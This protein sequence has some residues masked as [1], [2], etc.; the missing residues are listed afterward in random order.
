MI[1]KNIIALCKKKLY[2]TIYNTPE[3]QFI[4]DGSG[5]YPITNLPVFDEDT[6]C[7]TY[8]IPKGK[9]RFFVDSKLPKHIDVSDYADNESACEMMPITLAYCGKILIPVITATGIKFID[10]RYLA[11]LKDNANMISLWERSS[12]DNTSYFVV[13]NGMLFSGIISPYEVI[14]LEFVSEMKRLANL[15]EVALDN[16][17]S[18]KAEEQTSIFDNE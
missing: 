7:L 2:A 1:F 4:S 9:I 16:K 10:S 18:I 11:P 6:F 12:A 13:K 14:S 15:C 8:D 5:L 17:N 3:G